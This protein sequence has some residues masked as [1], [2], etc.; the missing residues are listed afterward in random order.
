[1]ANNKTIPCVLLLL[2]LV[3]AASLLPAAVDA[4]L[5]KRITKTY[6]CY[7]P[8]MH[9]QCMKLPGA[10]R[11]ECSVACHEGCIEAGY[12]GGRYKDYCGF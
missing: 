12:P 10:T 9:Q 3:V 1:M 2:G 11:E 8:C 7:C 4:R 5:V 6:L